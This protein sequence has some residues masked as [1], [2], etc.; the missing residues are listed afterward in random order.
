MSYIVKILLRAYL[1]AQQ[2]LTRVC[3]HSTKTD[4]SSCYELDSG[5]LPC[6]F[7]PE[8]K[9]KGPRYLQQAL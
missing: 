8:S 7:T 1:K 4:S 3:L 9:L 2:L 6:V 5:L